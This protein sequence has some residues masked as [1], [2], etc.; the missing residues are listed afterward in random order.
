MEDTT[1]PLIKSL[2]DGLVM[3][4]STAADA[5]KLADFN[6]RIHAEDEYD[7]EGVAAWTRDLLLKPH[8]TFRKSDFVIVEKEETGEIVSTS[9]LIS[10]TWLYDGI[11]FPLGRPELVGTLPEYR[12]RG[13]VRAVFEAIH[14][15]SHE[16]GEL[17]QAITGIPYFY[18]QF[19]YEMTV[20]LGGGRIGFPGGL[21]KLEEGQAEPFIIRTPLE[22]D[23]P[24][25][26][27][28]IARANRRSL[29][30]CQWD[31]AIVRHEIL[32]KSRENVNRLDLRVIETP[33]AQPVGYLA[34]PGFAWWGDQVGLHVTG[35]EL[36]E[37]QSFLAVTP[38][39]LRYL[40]STGQ[41]YA[42]ERGRTANSFGFALGTEHPVYTAAKDK[43]IV[44][45]KPYAFYMRVPDV[46]AF[47]RLITPV[48]EKRLRESDFSGH[49]GE[50]KIS[51]YRGGL[52]LA[53]EQG[54]L[55][56]IEEWKPEEKGTSAA[57]PGL[58]FLHLLFGHRTLDEIKH[59]F[60]D[61]WAN[62]EARVLLGVLFPKKPSS[63]WAVS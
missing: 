19:G 54:K 23:I 8:P 17:A 32:E 15:L 47:L 63:F 31:D 36:D 22:A 18:R 45:R 41:T 38:S 62:N 48:L 13:L 1:L 12:N 2:G 46:P 20:N 44:E 10:Q 42:A 3:R 5:E 7:G 39:V 24:F 9:N 21:P 55:T 50:L 27:R 34:H 40:W 43:L 33:Q 11:P 59:L 37:G 56:T 35:Y 52:R 61:C 16:R 60:V 49:S 28:M 26:V 25:L 4:Y 53:L 57:F 51:F 58:T 30:A 29:I 14:A 6:R